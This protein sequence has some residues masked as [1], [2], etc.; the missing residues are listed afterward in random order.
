MGYDDF[1]Y[2]TVKP[3]IIC[4]HCQ[5]HGLVRTKADRVKAGVSGG[6]ATGAILTAGAS[7]FL[8]GTLA[9]AKGHHSSVRI[10]RH[11]LARR[12]AQMS[13]RVA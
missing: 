3:Q 1:A 13:P 8:D 6:K 7:L 10:L 5:T 11:G 2:G 9:D 12:I 4:P